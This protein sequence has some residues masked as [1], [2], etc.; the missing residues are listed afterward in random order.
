M[1]DTSSLVD[2]V[3]HLGVET[4]PARAMSLEDVRE[5]LVLT[6]LLVHEQHWNTIA[7]LDTYRLLKAA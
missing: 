4:H 6:P 5:E 7:S 2:I 1:D 3:Q